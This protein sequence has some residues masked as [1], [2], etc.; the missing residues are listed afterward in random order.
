[1]NIGNEL[2]PGRLKWNLSLQAISRADDFVFSR[3][4]SG[5]AANDY[6][7]K[8][9]LRTNPSRRRGRGAGINPSGRYEPVSRHVFDD[10]WQT[11]DDLP[12]FKT[13]VQ[14]ENARTIITRNDSP[15]LNF[16][17]S[18]NPYRGCEHGCVYCFARP[19]HSYMGL[20]AGLDFET[21]LFAKPNAA[22]LLQKEISS[23]KYK[24]KSLAM[25]TNTDPYQPIEKQWRITRN[26][27]ETLDEAN[28][29][30]G[31]VTKSSLDYTRYRYS[32]PHGRTRSGA[33]C[34]FDHIDGP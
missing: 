32:F 4:F 13:S 10:G 21:K 26:I 15:D 1:M 8:S 2:L 24:V 14:K 33:C 17:Q 28:H 7:A 27:L 6:L 34:H 3:R 31:I 18:I 5:K 19:T 25:G 30:V 16:D 12:A 11:L 22:K 29:P 9:E 20:S 23:P